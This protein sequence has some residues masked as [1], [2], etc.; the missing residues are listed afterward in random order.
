[1]LNLRERVRVLHGERGVF[2]VERWG[3]RISTFFLRMHILKYLHVLF[4]PSIDSSIFGVEVKG[5]AQY[6]SQGR[7]HP[8]HGGGVRLESAMK[9]CLA[10]AVEQ[11]R[12]TL[13]DIVA[14]EDG[15][16]LPS[17]R[18]CSF[19]HLTREGMRPFHLT[20]KDAIQTQL[21]PNL[22]LLC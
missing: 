9:V 7:Q 16:A 19:C 2:G 5:V 13:Y 4:D 21:L 6:L 20:S 14:G 8:H 22:D 3:G 15:I 1:M 10:C 18:S 17:S 11:Q 12:S